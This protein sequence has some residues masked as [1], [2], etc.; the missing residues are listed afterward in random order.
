LYAVHKT[1]L[2][3]SR[4]H[5]GS[6]CKNE[7]NNYKFDIQNYNNDDDDDDAERCICCVSEHNKIHNSVSMLGAKESRSHKACQMGLPDSCT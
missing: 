6:C 2:E 1:N 4:K 3:H 7:I 5:T